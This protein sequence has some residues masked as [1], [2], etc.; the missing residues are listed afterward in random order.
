MRALSREWNLQQW[1]KFKRYFVAWRVDNL[2]SI[3][4]WLVAEGHPTDSLDLKIDYFRRIYHEAGAKYGASDRGMVKWFYE[5]A[6]K[7]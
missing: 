7:Y 2:I 6:E 4:K 1:E 3:R 5:R